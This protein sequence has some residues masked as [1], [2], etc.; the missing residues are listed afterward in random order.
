MLVRFRAARCNILDPRVRKDGGRGL[1]SLMPILP[2]QNPEA[3]AFKYDCASPEPSRDRL[4]AL[5]RSAP[6]RR[7]RE[8]PFHAGMSGKDDDPPLRF[9]HNAG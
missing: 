3:P 8:S 2:T 6:R 9:M 7:E 5:V 4:V 1:P